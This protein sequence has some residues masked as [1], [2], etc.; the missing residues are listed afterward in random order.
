MKLL[1]QICLSGLALCGLARS[2]EP[3]SEEWNKLWEQNKQAVKTGVCQVHQTKMSTKTVPIHYGLV[4]PDP[5]GPGEAERIRLFPHARQFQL[6]GCCP[7]P[8]ET[9]ADIPVCD[10]CVKAE[11]AWLSAHK[12]PRPSSSSK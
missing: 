11:A 5:N 3:T 10:A 4:R 6:G 9:T 8:D 12:K 2:A 1:L 7:I